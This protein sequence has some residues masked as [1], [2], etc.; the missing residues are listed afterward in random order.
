MNKAQKDLRILLENMQPF[1]HQEPYVFCSI[2][3]ASYNKLPFLPTLTF[4]EKEGI[5]II[6]TER[7]ASEQELSF[8]Q[9][10]A[11]ITLTVHSSLNAVGFLAAITTRLA[12]AGISANPVS[13]YYHDHLFVPW[14]SRHR[15]MSILQELQAST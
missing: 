9:T 6:A 8:D 3:R 5:S 13:A 7:Q 15:A 14:E 1:L 4:L 11:Q 10:W 2:D 12:E